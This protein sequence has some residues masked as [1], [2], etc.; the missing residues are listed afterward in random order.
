MDRSS[1]GGLSCGA[2]AWDRSF[3]H[4]PSGSIRNIHDQAQ[5][6]SLGALRGL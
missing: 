3:I 6:E 5:K 4:Y 2:I 1:K